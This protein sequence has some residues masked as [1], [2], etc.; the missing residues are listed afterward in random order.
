MKKY[1]LIIGFTFLMGVLAGCAGTG[2]TTQDQ[3]KTDAA[4]EVE[5]QDGADGVQTQDAAGAGDAV[6]LPDLTEQRPVAY[7]PCVR[8]DGVV[9]QDTGFVSSMPGCGNMDGEI[10]SQVDGTKLPDQDDQSNFGT[11]YA[12][13]RGGD[14]LLLVKMDER[15]E[16]FRD[17]DSTDSSI[18]PQVLHFTAEVKAVNEGS[19]LV[20]YISTAEGFSPLSEGEY[21]AS[22]DNLLDEV[23]VGDQVEIWCDGN[24]LETYPAQLGLVY[25]IAIIGR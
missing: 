3:A 12:Y 1:G 9:Y 11:G 24:I 2:S 15:M 13:Q 4:H 19:L 14:G 21:T 16:I 25:R 6:T 17:M 5:A 18:P 10:T 20:T 8:V 22:T 7:P 23:Q